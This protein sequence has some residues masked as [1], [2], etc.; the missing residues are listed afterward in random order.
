[1]RRRVERRH[2]A[3]RSRPLG[4]GRPG[5]A[6]EQLC[7]RDPRRRGLR[8]KRSRPPRNRHTRVRMR[9]SRSARSASEYLRSRRLERDVHDPRCGA[10]GRGARRSPR[11][12]PDVRRR[13]QDPVVRPP[14][15]H[16]RLPAALGGH[17]GQ[18]GDHPRRARGR[19][20]RHAR[21]HPRNDFGRLSYCSNRPISLTLSRAGKG[22]RTLDFDLGKVALYH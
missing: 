8:E 5:G 19:R 1:M 21:P 16:A 17:L 13:A 12:V 7:A 6:K 3:K 14:R 9:R 2:C 4:N 11:V 10:E 18:D 22:I 20:R 15:A